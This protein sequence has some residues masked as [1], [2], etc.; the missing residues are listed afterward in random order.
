MKAKVLKLT[1]VFRKR[2]ERRV[3]QAFFEA[4]EERQLL[5]VPAAWA[6]VG[7]GGGGAFFDPVFN[8]TN[9]SEIY[10]SSDMSGMYHSTDSGAN[11]SL[12]DYTKVQGGHRPAGIQFTS[13]SGLMFTIGMYGTVIKST[14]G[15]ANWSTVNNPGNLMGLFVDYNNP[16]HMIVSSYSSIYSTTNGGTSWNT[17]YTNSNGA[18]L[19]GAFFDGNNVYAATTT[20]VMTSSDGGA[21]F[22]APA[23]NGIN[24]G[25][26]G[27][28]SFAGAKSGSTTRFFC[29]TVTTD[30]CYPG[31]EGDACYSF[32][33]VYTM[34]VGGSWTSKN[35]GLPGNA[36][37]CYVSMLLND[38]N[39]V[40]LGG[41]TNDGTG[42]SVTKS[43]NAG[44]SWTAVFNTTNNQ[45]IQT[46]WMGYNGDRGW[47]Y[48][49]Y[50]DGM[51]V[52]PFDASKIMITDMGA[53][54]TSTNGGT[55]WKAAFVSQADLNA[56]GSSTPVGKAYHGNGLEDTTAW[57]LTWANSSNM[58]ASFT[59]IGAIRSTDS[60]S[61][62]S[63][64]YSGFNQG[65]MYRCVVQ[66]G[67]GYMFGAVST[68][69]DIYQWESYQD[70]SKIDASN[71]GQVLMSTNQGA[72]W[73]MVHDFQKPVVWATIDPNNANKM[74][75]SVANHAGSGTQGGIYV[76]SNINLGSSSTWT[77]VSN[78]PR[79][80][81]HPFNIVV[82]NDGTLVCTY[83]GRLDSN[84]NY[85]ASSGVFVSTDG[86]TTWADRSDA[87]M[88]YHT[89]DITIDPSDPT[90]NTW[91]AG[92]WTTN[93]GVYSNAGQIF[94]TTN[95]G[96]TWTP[97]LDSTGSN[98]MHRLEQVAINPSNANEAYV[99]CADAGLWYT[100]NLQSPTPTFSRVANYGFQ[101]PIRVFF[102]PYNSNEV[103]VTSF[104]YGVQKGSAAVGQAAKLG[105]GQQ[106]SNAVVNATIA[107]P[108]TVY[109]QDAN[110]NTVTTDNSNVTIS[111]NTGSGTLAGTLTRQAVNGVATFNDLSINTAGAFT[112]KVVDGSLTQAASNSFNIT[113]SQ[114]A[115]KLGFIQQPT[116]TTAGNTINPA[117]TVAV[118]DSGGNTVT[119]DN[120]TVTIAL[121]SGTG[122]LAGTLT[123]QAVN[124]IATFNNLSMTA[125]GAKTIQATDG[126]L[127]AATSGS[128]NINPA[129]ANKLAYQQQ[130]T[131]ATAGSSIS[132]AVTVL[133]QDTYGNT[134]TTDTSS[135]TVAL[136]SGTG[137]LSGTTTVAAVSGIATF[138]NLSVNLVGAK[139][140][141]VTDASLTAATSSSFNITAAAASKLGFIQAPTSTPQNCSITPAVTVAI[142]DTYGN[143]VTTSSANVTMALNTG[144]GTLSGTLTVAA[145]NG[146]ATFKN[147]SINSTGT[148]KKLQATSTGLTN[149]TSGTF[150]ITSSTATKLAV[151]Q[152][153]TNTPV[154]GVITPAIT[155]A[156][157]NSSGQT[158]TTNNTNVTIAIN[159]GS[160]TLAGTLTVQAVNGIATFNNL[161]I[162]TA[163]AF[164]L[165]VNDGTLTQATSNSFNITAAA[166][167][168]GFI[169]QP[170]NTT[171][172]NT[173]SPAVT[174][175]VQDASGA[176]VTTD[177][178]NVTIALY[179]GTGTL[180]GTLTA[181][182]V[183]GIATFNN[184]SMT[185]AGAKTLQATDGALTAAQSGSFT[186]NAAAANKLA[187]QQQPSNAAVNAA[188][189][190]PVTVLVQDTYGNTC[191]SDSSNVTIS[192]NTGTGTLAGTLTRQA[193]AGVATFN[194]LS[195]NTA[196][197][198]TLKVVDGGLTQA[199]SSSF[200]IT[201][202]TG[203]YTFTDL[204]DF[205][206]TNGKQPMST[207][208]AD[209]QGNL[210]GTTYIGGASSVGTVFKMDHTTHAITVL[211]TFNGAN[212]AN[213]MGGLVM[214]A[215]GNLY[216]TTNIGGANNLGTVFEVVS[217]SGTVTVLASFN[218]AGNGANP[219][220][221]LY[222]DAS[223]NL[224]GTTYA[225]GSSSKG[226]VFEVANGS[227]TITTLVTFTGTN[228]ASPM[229]ALSSD[230]GGNLYGTTSTGGANNA[231][232]IFKLTA[233]TWALTTL[234]DCAYADGSSP[235][236]TLLIDASGNIY[237]TTWGYNATG[238][239]GLFKIDAATHTYT[240]LYSF[241][242][243]N[244]T[245][246][247]GNLVMYG[248]CL[249]GT[250]G[251]TVFQ[252]SLTSSTLTTVN[253]FSWATGSTPLGLYVDANGNLFGA[254]Q[255]G[256]TGS[257][258]TIYELVLS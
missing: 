256:G 52:S 44:S 134:V 31:N 53:A 234:H 148:N 21:T 255:A 16:N 65:N 219:Q 113:A 91:Y 1:G 248:N 213:P 87:L 79:T 128:F 159:T 106:P 198:F 229:M 41:G 82:L 108:V 167:K 137:T 51:E 13:T 241:N 212:G 6:S 145:V 203:T 25:T 42:P 243:P 26:Q 169:Q 37:P 89:R 180:T 218:G 69:H 28:Y 168:L 221:S 3:A 121:Y 176:T 220:G 216:G 132:P 224:F 22:S 114:Q 72:S 66:P 100:S 175:A 252:Y 81:G 217:G 61:S 161:S 173:I 199:I 238:Q 2:A 60:G 8:P 204:A 195:I 84:W 138:N 206:T 141:R 11:W 136:N 70:D 32:V 104:G 140:L 117:V 215:S 223:G 36:K 122:T 153:P 143:T 237:G 181:Q 43:T 7:A 39:T 54:Y 64:N 225:G 29:V 185:A 170:S 127:T 94:K 250:T 47:G 123:A 144:T 20:G 27:L 209:A 23:A 17:I 151:I 9:T 236:S 211:A 228:G 135:V 183:N 253:T 12:M 222:R 245:A 59:D 249:Y 174:V 96:Q 10:C 189:S 102:N 118:Q 95:R 251:T 142:Q 58:W 68:C 103:W 46:G 147:L 85:T 111:I 116:N 112:L 162:N 231:G 187:F 67:T 78:P 254:C 55:S 40:Y 257:S 62:W 150:S 45:N 75:V 246:P 97:L 92:V 35:T 74:Y 165:K 163:G 258:G 184:L 202:G 186:I 24:T 86:G 247:M 80:E 205:N 188:I 115:T 242:A 4:L 109:V 38:I 93:N 131:N 57:G 164:T 149:V 194:D 160:G 214:D 34:D 18:P 124:G 30:Q 155:V 119:T 152:Q 196:G 98:N 207:L 235:E 230:A 192:I 90:Q 99:T 182:A 88:Q 166:T 226:T 120:S 157:Q 201:S 197:N 208:I 177:N 14:D 156:I 77:K 227:G 139:T 232:T 71:N 56:A 191:T 233:G 49:E 83:A 171:A 146:I 15:G 107:P 5:S 200:T 193:S 50:V 240:N 239:G 158:V 190:P 73:S 63:F 101:C 126:S 33:G 110:G 244:G 210:Y 133:V 179:S 154:N 19:A 172:G 130:P 178:S 105:F 125:A 76:S 48:G 129:A